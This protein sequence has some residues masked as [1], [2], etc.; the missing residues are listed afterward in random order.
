MDQ[1]PQPKRGALVMRLAELV[2]SLAPLQQS[3]D[4][5][6]EVTGITYDSREVK[7]GYLFVAIPGFH[8]DGHNFLADAAARGAAAAVISRNVAVPDQLTWFRVTDSRKA[9]SDLAQRFF[10]FPAEH[11]RLVGVTGTN[12]KTTTALLVDSILRAAGYGVGVV[13]TV[14]VRIGEHEYPVKHTTPEAADLQAYLSEMVDCQLDYAVI[15]VSSHALALNR[16]SGC[17]FDV[18]VFTNLT[19]DHLDLH[20]TM[21]AYLEAKAK[22]FA[23][24]SVLGKKQPKVAVINGDD[25]SASFL[26]QVT[27]V[28][29]ITYGL[30]GARDF[31]ASDVVFG[32]NGAS[33][34]L[35]VKG[36]PQARLTVVTPGL[37]SVY[38]A[39][40][41]IAVAAHE[42]V[43]YPVIA[44]A[45]AVAPSVPGRFQPVRLGQD[46]DVVVDYAHTPD[47]LENILKT[48]RE[49]ARGR[50][51][52]VF[53]CGGD[54]DRE[55]RPLMGEIADRLADMVVITSD[56]P[57]SENPAAIIADILEGIPNRQKI[58]VQPDRRSAIFAAISAASSG[59]VVLIAGKG[60]ETY[61]IFPDKTI[62][63]DDREVA[64]EA[65]EARTRDEL[66]AEGDSRTD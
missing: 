11:L 63:F 51:I 23:S 32:P 39:L 48:A 61:Q 28:P 16:V 20:G 6:R 22:L 58:A 66:D 52:I 55:K 24:L 50:V 56:N 29:V 9:L 19:Q 13:G 40:A 53:G 17:E 18:G 27:R 35:L 49:Y 38:N 33:F 1:L 34:N 43:P 57:R 15:E 59:D 5:M 64:K 60:H 26:Q 4:L 47:G 54:R 41:A 10:N 45:L 42:G 30:N 65:L 36:Q 44:D 8:V 46:F 12:G 3:G 62:H 2:L 14:K 31:A 21:Q 37:F 7:P 25:R